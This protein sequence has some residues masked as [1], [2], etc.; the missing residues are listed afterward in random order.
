M[1][2][3][4]F[5]I[6]RCNCKSSAADSTSRATNPHQI[7]TVNY[8]R[9]QSEALNNYSALDLLEHLSRSFI[10]S[11][12]CPEMQNCAFNLWLFPCK[13]CLE[14]H[15]FSNLRLA[16]R[17]GDSAIEWHLNDADIKKTNGL[18]K[19]AVGIL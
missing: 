12:S 1:K 13:N 8:R 18:L 5:A 2:L 15:S 7:G 9:E 16:E 11:T 6:Y 3:Q 19:V 14:S 17:V 4:A 10:F